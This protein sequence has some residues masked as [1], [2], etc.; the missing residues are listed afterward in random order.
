MPSSSFD[1]RKITATKLVLG[2]FRWLSAKVEG[3]MRLA[4]SWRFYAVLKFQ[5]SDL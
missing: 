2:P 3:S 4:S 1:A 5:V